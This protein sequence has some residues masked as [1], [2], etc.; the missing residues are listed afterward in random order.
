MSV[1]KINLKNLE[2]IKYGGTHSYEYNDVRNRRDECI[3]TTASYVFI[4]VNSWDDANIN[5]CGGSV[6]P[7]MEMIKDKDNRCKIICKAVTPDVIHILN[8]LKDSIYEL[9]LNLKYYH[10][11]Y[12][13]LKFLYEKMGINNTREDGWKN[14]VSDIEMNFNNVIDEINKLKRAVIKVN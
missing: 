4:Y 11:Y 10:V 8:E 7:F 3:H 13:G 9:N 5:V 1:E 2:C 6:V 12:N 14:D